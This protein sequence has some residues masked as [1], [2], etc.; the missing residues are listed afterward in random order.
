MASPDNHTKADSIP[1]CFSLLAGN[2]SPRFMRATMYTIPCSKDVLNSCKIPMG[3]VVQPFANIPHN[4]VS[5]RRLCW[6]SLGWLARHTTKD[7][8]NLL[9]LPPSSFSSFLSLP[10]L[11]LSL[12]LSSLSLSLS[13]SLSSLSLLFPLSLSLLLLLLLL[14]SFF[15][16]FFFPLLPLFL[17]L[18]LPSPLLVLPVLQNTLHLVDHGSGG[19]IRCNRCKAYMN[20]YARFIDGGRRYLCPICQCSNEGEHAWCVGWAKGCVVYLC[21]ICQ[22]SNEGEH[23][24]CVGWAKGCVV[25]LCPICQCY[26]QRRWA[27]SGCG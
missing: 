9:S 22:C 5:L 25:Y 12:S 19:P 23:A 10:P 7:T 13:L 11:S 18:S 20:P 27:I 6:V 21:P 4:E 1:V 16:F 14:S 8:R 17:S 3:L 15:F 26:Y 24:W 2:A